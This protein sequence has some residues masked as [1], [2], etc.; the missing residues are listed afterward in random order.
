MHAFIISSF[1]NPRHRHHRLRRLTRRRDVA[2]VAADDVVAA[3]AEYLHFVAVVVA[4][5][6]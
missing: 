1:S 2:V 4:V 6:G 5:H 3:N